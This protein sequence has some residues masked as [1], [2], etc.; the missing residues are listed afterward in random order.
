[1]IAMRQRIKSEN[2]N[3]CEVCQTPKESGYSPGGAI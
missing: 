2:L 3:V 1:M